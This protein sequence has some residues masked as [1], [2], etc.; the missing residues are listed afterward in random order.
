MPFDVIGLSYY[1]VFHEPAISGHEGQRGRA[2]HRV[3]QADR[4][5][6]DAVPVDA[7]ERQ[8][9][10][11]RQ[12]GRLRLGDQPAGARLPGDAGRP[13]VVRDRR[14]VHPG[15]GAGRAGRRAVLLGAGLDPRRARG[16]RG[17]HRLAERQHDPVQLRRRRRC[18]SMG[19]FQNPAGV[20][21]RAKP[22]AASPASS[23]ANGIGGAACGAWWTTGSTS[24][25]SPSATTSGRQA[26][27][28]G[29]GGRPRARRASPANRP[30]RSETR[31]QAKCVIPGEYATEKHIWAPTRLRNG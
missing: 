27:G 6:R 30:R 2:R 29:K 3:P 15:E 22:R 4:D 8:L 18:P 21:E 1:P 20:C 16:S 9:A 10:A 19:I 23:E 12:H 17:R 26:S 14:A 13:A 11:R 28:G 24:G 25:C 5:R 31:N 7:G